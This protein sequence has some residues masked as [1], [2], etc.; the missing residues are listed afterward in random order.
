MKGVMFHQDNAP[1]HESVVAMAA[2]CDCGIELVDDPP[3]SPDL[4]PSDYFLFPT[5]KNPTWLGSSI[6][7]MMRSYLQLRTFSNIRMRASIPQESKHC[8]TDGRNVWT[9]QET[10]MKNKP[11]M[12]KFDHCII[13]YI[14]TFQP[15]LYAV[16]WT[17]YLIHKSWSHVSEVNVIYGFIIGFGIFHLWH[18]FCCW[19]FSIF[20]QNV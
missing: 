9:A 6:G 16:H 2:V 18:I 13:V 3:Y 7:P 11:H 14:W 15:T 5:W 10:I 4:T 1:A 12:V 8:N 17:L 20:I 19:K